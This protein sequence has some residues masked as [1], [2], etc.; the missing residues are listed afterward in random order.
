M[1]TAIVSYATLKTAI[2]EWDASDLSSDV[3]VFIDMAEA[4]FNL[5][6]R[7]RQMETTDDL[8]PT[9]NVCTLPTDY[10][11]YKRVVEKASIRRKLAYI[12]EDAADE[13]YPTRSSGLAC[14]FMI[15]GETLSGSN[16]TNWLLLAHPNLYLHTCLLYAAEW[17]KDT[18][19][20]QTEATF[21]QNYVDLLHAADNRGKFAMAGVTLPGSVP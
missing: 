19:R 18:A 4:Y 16:T 14:H 3:D 17:R 21:V 5:K 8:T 7:L 20:L 6:L 13:L 12:T 10:I 2:S 15:L 9:S 11:E 1:A